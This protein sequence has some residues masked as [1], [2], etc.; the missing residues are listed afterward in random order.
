MNDMDIYIEMLGYNKY[1]HG[2]IVYSQD[3][4][5]EMVSLTQNVKKVRGYS[6]V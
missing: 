2:S 3:F 1:M 4:M 5:D 6:Y